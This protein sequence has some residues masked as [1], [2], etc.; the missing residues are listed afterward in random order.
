MS[1]SRPTAPRAARVIGA[2]LASGLLA[3]LSLIGLATSAAAHASQTGAEPAADSVLTTAPD[4]VVIT[5]DAALMDV[6][7]A[8]VV[9]DSAR[10]DVT[11][12]PTTVRANTITVPLR[13][14]L[15]AG[16]YTVAYRVV[17]ADGHPVST[18]YEFSVAGPASSAPATASM[19]AA[20]EPTTTEP[21][22]AE[23][24]TTEPGAPASL[25]AAPSAEAL[26]SPGASS[27]VSL[28]VL[29]LV[30]AVAGAGAVAL[31]VVIRRR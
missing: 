20:P 23:P 27:A 13:P 22:T 10:A 16:T 11:S 28:G 6:G 30:V 9:R 3:A 1:R 29:A 14:G 24:T 21:T 17:S 8:L 15:G 25:A 4:R 2:L 7:A 31:V 12:G 5:F 26:P 18:S 19:S